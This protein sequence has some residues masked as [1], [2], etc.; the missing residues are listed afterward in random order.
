MRSGASP[1]PAGRCSLQ[2]LLL[3]HVAPTDPVHR[4]L[5]LSCAWPPSLSPAPLQTSSPL[6]FVL[7]RQ[8][9]STYHSL[10]LQASAKGTGPPL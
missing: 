10:P 5:V 8:L 7:S 1:S 3:L 9:G 6:L 2:Q 4:N